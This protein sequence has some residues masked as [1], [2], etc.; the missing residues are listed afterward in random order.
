MSLDTTKTPPTP[1]CVVGGK[2][3][4]QTTKWDA[5]GRARGAAMWLLGVISVEPTAKMAAQVFGVSMPLVKEAVV[6]LE[7]ELKVKSN[8]HGRGNGSNGNGAVTYHYENGNS[9]AEAERQLDLDDLWSTTD[10]ADRELFVRRNL[11]TVWGVIES[12]TT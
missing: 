1:P 9:G 5:R 3:I 7:A 12:V 10:P 8:G 11:T 2:T 4:A 6:A